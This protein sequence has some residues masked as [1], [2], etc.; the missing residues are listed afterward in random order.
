MICY[1]FGLCRR[2]SDD[3]IRTSSEVFCFLA[4]RIPISIAAGGLAIANTGRAQLPLAASQLRTLGVCNCRWRPRNC[5]HWACAIARWRPYSCRHWACAIAA[6]G[7]AVADTRRVHTG[8]AQLPLA[9]S[10]LQTLRR[11]HTGVLNCRWRPYSCRLGVYNCR[12]WTRIC[13]H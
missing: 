1:N 6:S 4:I 9:A 8:R 3:Y 11:V 12:W 10:H 2:A 13:R 7:L 5:R